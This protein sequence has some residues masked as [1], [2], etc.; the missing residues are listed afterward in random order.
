MASNYSDSVVHTRQELTSDDKKY[1]AVH[2]NETDKIRKNAIAEI[3]RWIEECDDL[4]IQINKNDR[5]SYLKRIFN[6]YTGDF[7]I[8]RFL[9]VCKFN[10]EKTKIRMQNYYKQR[11]CLP[12]WYMNKNPFRPELQE[13]LDLGI[14]LPLR[15]PD[16]HGRL[17][18]IIYGTRH[19]PKKHKI[20][21]I[22][23]MTEWLN[24]NTSS[25]DSARPKCFFLQIVSGM[26]HSRILSQAVFLLETKVLTLLNRLIGLSTFITIP[27]PKWV[28]VVVPASRLAFNDDKLT[29]LR[30]VY[31]LC[32]GQLPSLDLFHS[33]LVYANE[34]VLRI[35]RY[36]NRVERIYGRV[37]PTEFHKIISPERI[38]DHTVSLCRHVKRQIKPRRDCAP[39]SDVRSFIVD[40]NALIITRRRDLDCKAWILDIKYSTPKNSIAQQYSE[41]NGTFIS[42]TMNRNAH[43]IQALTIH[44]LAFC[45][46]FSECV[47][48]KKLRAQKRSFEFT[49]SR[50]LVSSRE[51]GRQS[52]LHGRMLVQA[53]SSTDTSHAFRMTNARPPW[54]RGRR[55]PTKDRR[56]KKERSELSFKR[57]R[58]GCSSASADFVAS[59]TVVHE[60]RF[61]ICS[62]TSCLVSEKI[63][64]LVS[65]TTISSM[66]EEC[67]LEWDI[68]A[69]TNRTDHHKCHADFLFFILSFVGASCN[70]TL[71]SHHSQILPKAQRLTRKGLIV[72]RKAASAGL[73]RNAVRRI[74]AGWLGNSDVAR[75]GFHTYVD[76]TVSDRSRSATACR[77][78]S[79][80]FV[81]RRLEAIDAKDLGLFVPNLDG[82]KAAVSGARRQSRSLFVAAGRPYVNHVRREETS[83]AILDRIATREKPYVSNWDGNKGLFLFF[84]FFLSRTGIDWATVL[85]LNRFYYRSELTVL[86][87]HYVDALLYQRLDLLHYLVAVVTHAHIDSD[88]LAVIVELLVQSNLELEL[89]RTQ[90]EVLAHHRA[91]LTTL[92]RGRVLDLADAH[93]DGATLVG[94]IGLRIATVYLYVVTYATRLAG[95]VGSRLKSHARR[96]ALRE[97]EGKG[98][99]IRTHLVGLD[100]GFLICGKICSDARKRSFW[101]LRPI[102]SSSSRP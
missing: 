18:M 41:V 70:D 8:L 51:T 62:A 64:T 69:E 56:R 47:A 9:R 36:D 66:H 17:V 80:Y 19:D 55:K 89:A 52:L 13:L 20:A 10:L 46:T 84:V 87:N 45:T 63:V 15:K 42:L 96:R 49:L 101:K 24:H 30:V 65:D 93:Q 26:S 2:L 83:G 48:Q 82:G 54:Q 68:I 40:G 81:G 23:K 95:L 72:F 39:P 53:T 79:S 33:L 32:N 75:Q 28:R 74:P 50:L 61:P 71:P 100:S 43:Y 78:G 67:T 76:R 90:Q 4:R 35:S 21:D 22:A 27:E 77:H 37:L 98:N 1:A 5:V 14:I 38:F 85:C 88:R 92:L 59:S 73:Q 58:D 7:L 102:T 31:A 44:Q 25:E 29:S 94:H 3:K 11:F 57:K 34:S 12:E 99:R 97:C 16:N 6:L 86:K 60:S 91:R